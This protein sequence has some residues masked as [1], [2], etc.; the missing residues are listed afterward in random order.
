[1]TIKKPF[2]TSAAVRNDAPVVDDWGLV[3]RGLLYDANGNPISLSDLT[4]G[5]N[6][7]Q[8]VNLLEEILVRLTEIRD[9]LAMMVD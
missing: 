8:M 5:K 4:D 3:V 1:M 7:R 2:V 9:L 6:D